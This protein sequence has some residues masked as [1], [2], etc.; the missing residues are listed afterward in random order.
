MARNTWHI[1]G[2]SADKI[3]AFIIDKAFSNVVAYTMTQHPPLPYRLKSSSFRLQIP[4]INIAGLL[5]DTKFF[6]VM[7]Q[8]GTW[9]GIGR[10]MST[11]RTWS[12]R[13]IWGD[14]V[15]KQGSPV[16]QVRV[17]TVDSSCFCNSMVQRQYYCRPVLHGLAM[18]SPH[19]TSTRSQTQRLDPFSRCLLPQIR[20]K[21]EL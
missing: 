20:F 10:I 5:P 6:R 21:G 9:Q 18:C 15:S 3:L 1:Q 13:T 7:R 17:L 4:S 2:T 16:P 8:S 14:R 12:R 19:A 11:L